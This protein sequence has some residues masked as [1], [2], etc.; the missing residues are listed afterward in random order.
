MPPSTI[1]AIATRVTLTGTTKFPVGDGTAVQKFTDMADIDAWLQAQGASRI[2]MSAIGTAAFGLSN[3]NTAQAVFP[4]G[5]RTVTLEADKTYFFEGRYIL[6]TG[7][8]THTTGMSFLAG[9]GLTIQ[10]N[11]C[12]YLSWIWSSAANA[13]VTASNSKHNSGLGNQVLNATSALARTQIAFEG[14]LRTSVGGTITPQITFSAAPG[15]TN[16]ALPGT[17]IRFTPVPGNGT[18][19]SVGTWA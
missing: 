8:T 7:T 19:V 1:D 2:I 14:T 10:T 4:T 9:G 16:Q 11:G 13:T 17:I 3:V 12:E 18:V 6:A 5:Q 15:G